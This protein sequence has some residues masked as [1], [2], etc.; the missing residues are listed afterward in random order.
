[1]LHIRRKPLRMDTT[2]VRTVTERM[3][4]TPSW[5]HPVPI[6]PQQRTANYQVSERV[7]Y[8][9]CEICGV[10]VKCRIIHRVGTDENDNHVD[11]YLYQPTETHT[12]RSV[13]KRKKDEYNA[14]YVPV[15]P[16]GNSR[17]T[18]MVEKLDE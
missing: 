2:R 13:E 14:Q 18:G 6:P 15:E 17:I 3:D 5:L 1:V 4:T 12:C 16:E 8:H 9:D 11:E 7:D 10:R